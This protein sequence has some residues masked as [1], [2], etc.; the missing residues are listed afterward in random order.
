MEHSAGFSSLPH[1]LFLLGIFLV[2]KMWGTWGILEPNPHD[3]SHQLLP[4]TLDVQTHLK[5]FLL[6]DLYRRRKR[7]LPMP[8][9]QVL[10]TFKDRKYLLIF[11]LLNNYMKNMHFQVEGDYKNLWFFLKAH[12]PIR[13]AKLFW[14]LEEI[15]IFL[16]DWEPGI[17]WRFLRMVDS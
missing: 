3:R 16:L 1:F 13:L 6:G 15:M 11:F 17:Y 8:Y 2:P 12:S 5:C 10:K 4:G 7:A 14:K 9:Y